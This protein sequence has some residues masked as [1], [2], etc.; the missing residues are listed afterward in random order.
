MIITNIWLLYKKRPRS[1]N[2]RDAQ[3]KKEFQDGV[4]QTFQESWFS[5]RMVVELP[6]SSSTSIESGSCGFLLGNRIILS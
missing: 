6:A 4:S 1:Q 2:E 3:K 5:P